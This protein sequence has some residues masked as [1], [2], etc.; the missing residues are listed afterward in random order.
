M[1]TIW[2]LG[3]SIWQEKQNAEADFE[4][5]KELGEYVEEYLRKELRDELAGYE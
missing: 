5:K 2:N 1:I 3:K 4:K